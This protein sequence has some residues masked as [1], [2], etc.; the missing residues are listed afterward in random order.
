MVLP[1]WTVKVNLVRAGTKSWGHRGRSSEQLRRF[2]VTAGVSAPFKRGHRHPLSSRQ[3]SRPVQVAS[4][5]EKHKETL[6]L[7]AA[8]RFSFLFLRA[9][10]S[11][12]TPSVARMTGQPGEQLLHVIPSPSADLMGGM[13]PERG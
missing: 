2:Q 13:V 11:S 9:M 8:G 7:R 5:A 3:C 12:A 10:K 4:A 6:H 1:V